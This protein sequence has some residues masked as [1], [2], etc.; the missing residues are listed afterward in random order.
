MVYAAVYLLAP[1]IPPAAAG[2]GA[3]GFCWLIEFAQL[4][5]IP[6]ALSQHSLLARLVLGVQFDIVDVAWYPVGVLPLVAVHWLL[7]ARAKNA[8]SASR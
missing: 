4:T 7:T 2:A 1:R 8:P 5:G 3:V 6:A